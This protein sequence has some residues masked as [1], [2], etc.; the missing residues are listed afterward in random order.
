MIDEMLI[1][2]FLIYILTVKN[3]FLIKINDINVNTIVFLY[4]KKRLNDINE[5][6]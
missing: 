6:F 5:T 1:D 4:K 3:Y 2:I